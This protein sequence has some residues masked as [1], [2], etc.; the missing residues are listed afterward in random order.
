[1]AEAEIRQELG[2]LRALVDAM[3]AEHDTLIDRD[4]RMAN[5]MGEVERTHAE[6]LSALEAAYVARDRNRDD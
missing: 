3:R 6:R 4:N 1:M 5:R 2:Q